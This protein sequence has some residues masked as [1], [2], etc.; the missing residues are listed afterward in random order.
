MNEKTTP[1][2]WAYA[3]HLANMALAMAQPKGG[4]EALATL[5]QKMAAGVEAYQNHIRAPYARV[6][7]VVWHSGPTRL[8]RFMPP[9]KTKKPALL[10]VPSF[11][12]KWHIFDLMPQF[13]FVQF[14]VRQ[15]YPVYVLDWREPTPQD[16]TLTIN[17]LILRRLLPV[18]RFMQEKAAPYNAL[19]YCLGGTLLAASL[20]RWPE[21]QKRLQHFIAL[22]TPWDFHSGETTLDWRLK[23]YHAFCLPM[24]QNLGYMPAPLI[25][26]GFSMIDPALWAK[27]YMRFF[28][29][30]NANDSAVFVATED[31]LNDPVP[32]G[33]GVAL[34]LMQGFYAEN[35][36][37]TNA[38][39]LGY[40]TVDLTKLKTPCIVVE[41]YD[42]RIVPKASSHALVQALP[43]VQS[44]TA[45]SGHIGMMASLK[46]APKLWQHLETYLQN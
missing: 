18:L 8:L 41:G 5:Q 7:D 40:E 20:A 12:N 24:V 15:G 16:H 10:C 36:P 31:W 45:E 25:Q 27:K 30:E 1:P 33:G 17:D 21:L 22:G 28:D 29:L 46:A 26:G 4:E 37:H 43:R 23:S 6:Y 42:D 2:H 9:T 11:I 14:F 3:M 13:S 34:Q 32:L 44:F 38:W 35:Q 39:Q 19:G